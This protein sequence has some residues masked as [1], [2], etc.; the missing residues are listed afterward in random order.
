MQGEH[1]LHERDAYFDRHEAT[2]NVTFDLLR[3]P[4]VGYTLESVTFDDSDDI[5]VLVLLEHQADLNQL[6]EEALGKLELV[7]LKT[8]LFHASHGH[9]CCQF[10]MTKLPQLHFFCFRH[11]PPVTGPPPTNRHLSGVFSGR[12]SRSPPQQ[13]PL[14]LRSLS[15]SGLGSSSPNEVE[16]LR[17]VILAIRARQDAA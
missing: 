15:T 17:K 11:Q 1:E 2:E 13:P 14:Q 9:L 7:H 16:K 8:R 5:N 4:S 12:T 3:L 10:S 6:L